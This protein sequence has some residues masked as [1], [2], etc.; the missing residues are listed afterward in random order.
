L[1]RVVGTG[2][3]ERRPV[4]QESAE[5]I[6]GRAVGNASEALQPKGGAT[7]RLRRKRRFEG[8]NDWERQVGLATHERTAAEHPAK[9]GPGA[10]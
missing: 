6:V 2:E 7:D 4:A 9:A 8:P 5:G 1:F 10:G 3:A